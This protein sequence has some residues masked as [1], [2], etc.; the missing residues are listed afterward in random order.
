M[1]RAEADEELHPGR[2]GRLCMLEGDA[3]GLELLEDVGEA[4]GGD[5]RPTTCAAVGR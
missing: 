3:E 5:L 2:I 1:N 4:A